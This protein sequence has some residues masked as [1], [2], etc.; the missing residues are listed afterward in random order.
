MEFIFSEQNWKDKDGNIVVTHIEVMESNGYA[1][2]RVSFYPNENAQILS[3]VYVEDRCRRTGICTEMLNAIKSVLTR[4]YTIVYVD[5][6][7]PDYVRNT[8]RKQGYSIES[9]LLWQYLNQK[10]KKLP[11][12]DS[13]KLLI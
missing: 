13:K 4:P 7:A 3:N 2:C 8:Y 12:I 6:W 1:H 5:E 11:K 10:S 9:L